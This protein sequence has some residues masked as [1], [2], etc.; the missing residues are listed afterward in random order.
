[1]RTVQDDA[2]EFFSDQ[3]LYEFVLNS[4]LNGVYK[5]SEIAQCSKNGK[6]VQ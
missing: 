5:T 4:K 1:M 3:T 6:I 2:S